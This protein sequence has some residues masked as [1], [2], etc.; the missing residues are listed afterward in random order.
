MSQQQSDP[1][2]SLEVEPFDV[3][4]QSSE[5]RFE[6]WLVDGVLSFFSDGVTTVDQFR[7][8]DPNR[9]SRL[10]CCC[11]ADQPLVHEC[12]AATFQVFDCMGE[13]VDTAQHGVCSRDERDLDT[14]E[15]LNAPHPQSTVLMFRQTS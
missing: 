12:P 15:M 2:K 7:A 11:I 6:G 3:K 13:L 1:R 8:A 10:Q 14:V 9:V 5:L 4:S